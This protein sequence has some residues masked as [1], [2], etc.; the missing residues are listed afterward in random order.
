VG[1]V[2]VQKYAAARTSIN[3]PHYYQIVR[4]K[5][6]VADVL[7]PLAYLLE[8]DLE[9]NLAVREPAR[10]QE[11]L[12]ALARLKKDYEKTGVRDPCWLSMT[13]ACH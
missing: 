8:S 6:L 2:A 4:A 1:A 3:S 12:D 9:A 13:Y 11:D 10:L 7:P 5:D